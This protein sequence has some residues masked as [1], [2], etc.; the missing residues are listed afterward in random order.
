MYKANTLM[1]SCHSV[2]F[3]SWVCTT[4]M[5]CTKKA[6][7]EKKNNNN[8]TQFLSSFLGLYE[9]MKY[10][11]PIESNTLI[12]YESILFV[13]RQKAPNYFILKQQENM[14]HDAVGPRVMGFL[15]G[16]YTN[17]GCQVVGQVKKVG[18]SRNFHQKVGKSRNFFAKK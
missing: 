1:T 18:K 12:S 6:K 17:A 5:S 15:V 8:R 7:C 16:Y 10:N 13:R 3:L 14:Y 4:V 9:N 11:I 2:S